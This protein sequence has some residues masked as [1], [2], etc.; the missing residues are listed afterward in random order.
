MSLWVE[1]VTADGAIL[2]D[3]LIKEK[4]RIFAKVFNIQENELVFFNG[5]LQKFKKRNNIRR[6]CIH[7]ELGSVPLASLSEEC[8]KLH[9]LLSRFTLDQ[10]YNI[11]ETMAPN[12]TLSSTPVR[13][14]KKNKIRVTILLSVNA[15]GTH[16][17]KPWVIGNSKH[18][19]PLS[20]I[21]LERLS[22]YYHRN[23]KAWMN[24]IIFEEVLQEIDNYF[25]AQNKKILL[26][27]DNA[28][29]HFD[30]HF[31]QD[32][33][34]KNN[35]S[36]STSENHSRSGRSHGG[37]GCGGRGHGRGGRSGGRSGKNQPDIFQLRLTHVKVAFLFPNI[38]SH[39][40]PLDARII[41]SF[42]NYYKRNYCCHNHV[43]EET[44]WNCW[45]K[46]GILPSSTNEDMDNASQV[47]QKI[48]DDKVADLNQMIGELNM[49]DFYTFSL[50]DALNNFFNDLEEKILTEA[51]LS[52]HDIIKLIQK[53]IYENKKINNDN[54]DSKEPALVS[55]DSAMKSLQNWMSFF[56]Q[57]QISEFRVENMEIFKR[58]LNLVKQ[59]E[60]K[61]RK[62]VSITNFF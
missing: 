58:Y 21:N 7:G 8:A 50:A 53:E 41:A 31:F 3:L 32:D 24:S 10:I 38:T 22:V 59:L 28:P 1:N 26:L 56:K 4:A 36:L 44:I 35:E 45:K 19:R 5:W 27:I 30:P 17:L 14:Q 20:K 46:T 9:Q 57:Q 2:T 15:T 18:P 40:Q 13:D 60:R 52:Y 48:V 6:F 34:D 61:S 16:K 25:K 12:Q 54:N 29:S 23:P 51:I 43:T 55:L 49:G 47:Q 11:D 33:D 62:Q 42:K 37:R 39:L